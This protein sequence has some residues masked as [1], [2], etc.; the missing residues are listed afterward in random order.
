MDK[1]LKLIIL[2][3]EPKITEQLAWHLK[4]KNLDVS[5]VNKAEDAF[6][7]L[8]DGLFDIFLLD[9]MMP[10]IGG[11]DVLEKVKIVSPQTSVIM[12]SG[13][14]DME[15]VIQ[16]MRFGAVDF[17]R[18]PFQVMD[19]IVAIERTG[20][21]MNLQ[22]KLDDTEI[23]HTL[24]NLELE[25]LVDKEFIGVSKIIK[26]VTDLALR[27][28]SDPGVNVLITGENG[29]GKEIVSRI[30]HFA[31]PRKKGIFIPVNS[32]AIPENLLE[33]EF[34][35]HVKGAFTDARED[36]KGYLEIASGG[37]LFLDEIGDM[38]VILQAKLLRALEERKIR[39]VGSSREIN[40]DVRIIS[41]TNKNPSELIREGRFRLDLYHRINAIEINIPPLREHPE[42]I[43][44]ILRHFVRQIA[45]RKNC[46]EP[47]INNEVF[48]KLYN[49]NFPGNVRELRNLAERAMI[50]LEG[51]ELRAADFLLLD[52]HNREQ[53]IDFQSNF[54]LDQAE[55]MI[56]VRALEKTCFNQTEASMLLGISRDALK[57][58]IAK[59]NIDIIKSIE[60]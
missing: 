3:D 24:L 6:R 7:L 55:K 38:P 53:I 47:N 21:L 33:S 2:D 60:I 34:F 56:I 19:I 37:T 26:S 15:M 5:A 17:I 16:A 44:P 22:N 11:M 14:G 50:L 43:E 1:M 54:N 30:I 36:K 18:K 59:F 32:A 9:V 35:G 51:T 31:S 41:A 49:Y 48:K 46:K 23:R 8:H 27:V 13:Y 25:R 4:K 29:T 28:A 39:R 10:G 52:E 45:I 12:M 42:D 20:K 58:K 57:R 40:V